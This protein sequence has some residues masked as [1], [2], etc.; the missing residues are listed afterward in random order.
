MK[1]PGGHPDTRLCDAV[2]KVKRRALPVFIV[3]FIVNYMDRVNVGFIQA[4]LQRDLGLDAAAYGLGAGLFFIGYAVFEIPSNL[5]LQRVGARLWLTRIT[6]VWGLVA[7]LMAFASTERQFQLLRLA[8]GAAEA[9]FFP[10]VIYHFTRWLPSS[11]R[12]KA[13]ALFLSGSAI[14]SVL[15]GPVSGVLMRFS[16]PGMKGWQSMLFVEGLFSVAIG[17]AAW[18]RLDSLPRDARWLT[19]GEKDA[20]EGA[21]AEEQRVRDVERVP[22]TGA[23]RMLRDPQ[24]VLFCAVYFAVQLTIYAATFWLPGIIRK[25]GS[26]S[27]LQVGLLNSVPWSM[28]ILG[29]YLAAAGAARWGRPQAW[30]AGALVLAA[31][32]MFLSTIGGPVLAFVCLCCAALGFKSASSLFWPIPQGYLAPPVSAAAIALINSIGN[33]GGFV[34]PTVFGRLEKLTGSVQHGLWGLAITSVV[35]AGLVLFTRTRA[36]ARN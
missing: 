36:Q 11:E 20:L 32:G 29:M 7:S 14:A 30:V 12:G 25:M 34:A 19:D 33:L 15:S 22:G 27:D 18:F 10:G 9:G 31:T 35:A 26:L 4:H 8:L 13:V 1:G 17:L 16:L 24:L 6:V 2:A 5:L 3:M 23:F 21:I 28:S